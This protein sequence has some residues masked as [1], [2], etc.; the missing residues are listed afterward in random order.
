MPEAWKPRLQYQFIARRYYLASVR[1][2]R[3]LP[4]L[5]RTVDHGQYVIELHA[6]MSPESASFATFIYEKAGERLLRRFTGSN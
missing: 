5:Q 4:S 3:N 6:W 2:M 1:N